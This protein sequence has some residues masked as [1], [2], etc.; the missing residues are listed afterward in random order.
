MRRSSQLRNKPTFTAPLL[1]HSLQTHSLKLKST[2]P[3][4]TS[5][6]H[7]VLCTPSETFSIRQAQTSNSIYLLQPYAVTPTTPP[8]LD[9]FPEIPQTGLCVVSTATSYLELLPITPNILPHLYQ[10]LP[11]YHG[12]DTSDEDDFGMQI[13][14]LNQRGYS[15]LLENAS[16]SDGEFLRAWTDTGGFE[17]SKIA[18]RPSASLSLQLVNKISIASTLSQIPLTNPSQPFSTSTLWTSL[19]ESSLPIPLLESFLRRVCDPTQGTWGSSDSG[20]VISQPRFASCIGKLLL[21][22][23]HDSRKNNSSLPKTIKAT[24][25]LSLPGFLKKWK[26]LLVDVGLECE[27]D[28]SLEMVK[29]WYY[30]PTTIT[31]AWLKPG[32]DPPPVDVAADAGEGSTPKPTEGAG[33]G[34][35]KWHEKFAARKRKLGG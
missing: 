5:S 22:A 34:R 29:G 31:I 4:S 14:P 13:D 26:E 35:G 24:E 25:Y 7:A 9:I 16:V 20:W 15:E 21:E 6:G 3:S 8:G 30:L 18:H 10:T 23:D 12:W 19:D 28:V 1:N 11:V 32:L 33:K 2:P 17:L 27:N